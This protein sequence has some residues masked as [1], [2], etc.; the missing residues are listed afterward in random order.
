MAGSRTLV[1]I[2]WNS[3][4]ADSKERLEQ[5]ATLVWGV[6]PNR[7][8]ADIVVIQE[9]A[10]GF[11]DC[12]AEYDQLIRAFKRQ[13][14][15]CDRTDDE[16]GPSTTSKR[17]YFTV[18]NPLRLTLASPTVFIT[19]LTAP[20]LVP[21]QQ[22]GAGR[23]PRQRRPVQRLV[24]GALD[25]VN[26][27]PYAFEFDTWIPR[28]GGRLRLSLYTWHVSHP[29][30]SAR[31]RAW[32]DPAAPNPPPV[33]VINFTTRTRIATEMQQA[34]SGQRLFVLAGDL[35]VKAG[36]LT[37][38]Y[39][40]AAGQRRVLFPPGL[41]FRKVSGGGRGWDHVIAAFGNGPQMTRHEPGVKIGDHIPLQATIT[42]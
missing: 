22:P 13:G 30:P 2:T 21:P 24:A 16:G 37:R 23:P 29:F 7:R 31:M 18:W 17:S 28:A 19:A 4:G 40:T 6:G 8:F 14:W 20:V 42:V 34:I 3:T 38:G 12:Q 11:I 10:Q 25:T 41:G 35:N 36:V 9:F 32:P 39:Q 26:N 33:A 15:K 1:L 5:I 27:P